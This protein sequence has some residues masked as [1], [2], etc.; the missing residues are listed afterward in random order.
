M[1]LRLCRGIVQSSSNFV[2]VRCKRCQNVQKL[3]SFQTLVKRGSS[4]RRSTPERDK[5]DI[6]KI[7][8]IGIMAH[9]DA[10]KTTT[11][12]RMLYYSGT[13][14]HLGDVD[15]GDTVTDYMAQERERGITITSAAVTF[16]WD[17]HRINLI[18]TPGHVDFTV[19]VERSLRVLDGA[20]AVFDSSAGVEAQTV[21]VWNQADRYKIPRLAFLNKMD[22]KGADFEYSVRSIQ[23]KLQA[24]PLPLQIPI[25]KEQSFTG[26]VDLVT[27]EVVTWQQTNGKNT[28]GKDFIKVPL[29]SEK[30]TALWEEAVN[31]RAQLVEKL[32]DLDDIFAEYML[33]QDEFDALQVPTEEIQ[34]AIR[35]VTLGNQAVPLLCGSSLKNKGVQML[36]DAVNRYLP[37]PR[38]RKQEVVQ[39]YKNDLCA[40]AFKV[41]HDK[42]RGPLVFLRIYFGTIKSQGGVYNASQDCTERISRLLWVLADDYREVSSMEA[43]NIAVAVG[44]KKTVTGDTLVSSQPAFRIACKNYVNSHPQ[45][46]QAALP[47]LEGVTVPP[48][49]FFCTIEPPS[50][51]FQDDLEKALQ[52]LQHEDPSLH[53]RT[54]PD[55]GQTVLSGMGELHLEIIRDRIQKEYRIEAELGPLQIAYRECIH[56]S[57]TQSATLDRV[58]GDRQ[59]RA[60]VTVSV[61][62]LSDLNAPTEIKLKDE[63]DAYD[64]HFQAALSGAETA[65]I[66]G[67]VISFPVMGVRITV[68]NCH[69]LPGTSASVISA[70]ATQAVHR[71]LQSAGGA[72]MEPIMNVE[73]TTNESKLGA[74]LGDLSKRRGEIKTVDSHLRSR[75][76]IAKCPLAEMVGYST[77]LRTITS[78]AATCSIEFSNYRVM[79]SSDQ[80]KT[81]KNIM[82]IL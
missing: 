12:E 80:S 76:V 47:L 81:I 68:T 65:S 46:G 39:F 7:R 54:D 6:T 42:Q 74:V 3:F 78:G 67:P 73:V 71:A 35:R 58:I 61:E 44:L 15:D 60:I 20:I 2:F 26:L 43:G 13:T 4:G 53:V 49:V 66:Q 33:T 75:V 31:G 9:I 5:H 51:A 69:I 82:G 19:E 55:T 62:P 36:M 32:A 11:T 34:S 37:N 64:E 14:K 72:I 41:I 50:Q 57:A 18:D 8:N 27:M 1:M 48:P 70:C 22:K 63:S 10:G 16:F 24:V 40:Y 25:G 45:G 28:H 38:E 30:H 23:D 59:H 17:G 52:I 21:T 29:T 56:G 77:K 79:T